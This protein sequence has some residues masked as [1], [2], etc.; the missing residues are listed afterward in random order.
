MTLSHLL[1]KMYSD[2]F[3]AQHSR[4]TNISINFIKLASVPGAICSLELLPFPFSMDLKLK[5]IQE[6]QKKFAGG[7]FNLLSFSKS[8]S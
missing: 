1:R 5:I 7:K 4:T 6:F 3:L 8:S 2:T